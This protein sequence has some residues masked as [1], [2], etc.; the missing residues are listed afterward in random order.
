M[1]EIVFD[2]NFKFC[3]KYVPDLK[4]RAQMEGAGRSGSQNIGEGSKTSGTSKQS[5]LRLV[6]V[7]RAS[8]EELKLDYEA[9]LR[10][11]DLKQWSKDDSKSLAVRRL[12][13]QPNKSYKT[14]LSNM[15]NDAIAANC[16]LCV[17]NQACYLLDKQLQSL[18]KELKQKG[19][20]KNR[21][22]EYKKDLIMGKDDNFD[23]FLASQGMRRLENGQVVKIN[24]KET[25]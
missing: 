10:Q 7:A 9:Y 24:E 13:Y 16:L 4:M 6:Q 14:Y 1:A 25:I 22:K 19:D 15:N 23:E 2:L 11:R 5:E 3:Q 20:F 8:L 18:E 17:I 12:A 21:L